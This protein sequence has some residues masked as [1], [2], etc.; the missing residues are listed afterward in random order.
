MASSANEDSAGD[1]LSVRMPLE[2]RIEKPGAT[3][4][5]GSSSGHSDPGG[6]GVRSRKHHA[7][8][9][10]LAAA[11]RRFTIR[12]RRRY[13]PS[14]SLSKSFPQKGSSSH[15]GST[16]LWQHSG[17]LAKPT[18]CGVLEEG[19]GVAEQELV[20]AGDRKPLFDNV[21]SRQR[22]RDE[23]ADGSRNE[24]GTIRTTSTAT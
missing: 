12:Q 2:V 4:D 6:D 10:P 17:V 3:F 16:L 22:S 23:E 24:N 5:A 14:G 18:R 9:R 8:R 21:D 19:L 1:T 13:D 20:T 11:R 7:S 15:A